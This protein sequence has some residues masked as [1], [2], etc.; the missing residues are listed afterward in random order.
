MVSFCLIFFLL[1]SALLWIRPWRICLFLLPFFWFGSPFS[2]L[3]DYDARNDSERKNIRKSYFP[4][5]GL[6]LR[7]L[8]VHL[9]SARCVLITNNRH[10]ITNTCV[11]CDVLVRSYALG[12]SLVPS[13]FMCDDFE[14]RSLERMHSWHGFLYRLAG[15]ARIRYG[16]SLDLFYLISTNSSLCWKLKAW[17]IFLFCIEI[18]NLSGG[19]PF[20]VARIN[21][22]KFRLSFVSAGTWVSHKTRR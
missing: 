6:L 21:E 9:F 18:R 7:E 5:I 2:W 22:K 4:F 3:T 10:F 20:V 13:A 11:H 12:S 15:L 14:H 16:L 8:C 19:P 1:A 17:L